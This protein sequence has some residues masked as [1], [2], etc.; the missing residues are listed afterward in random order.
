MNGVGVGEGLA[1]AGRL[2]GG[3]VDPQPG[4]AGQRRRASAL[5]LGLLLED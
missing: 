1:H 5:V 3:G 2:S 4:L